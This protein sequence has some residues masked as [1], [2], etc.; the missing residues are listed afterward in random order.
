MSVID[1]RT[2]QLNDIT[3][4]MRQ[5]PTFGA[6]LKLQYD[7]H[8]LQTQLRGERDELARLAQGWVFV[9]PSRVR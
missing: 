7:R 2:D 4:R 6:F 5:A 8:Q 3:A 1:Q 9:P